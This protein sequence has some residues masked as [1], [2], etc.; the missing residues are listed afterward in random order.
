MVKRARDLGGARLGMLAVRDPEGRL[1]VRALEGAATGRRRLGEPLRSPRW[2]VLM[3]ERVPLVTTPIS[4]PSA[5]TS[6]A[7]SRTGMRSELTRPT[8]LREAPSA[9]WRSMTAAPG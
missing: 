8:R 2:P 5:L 1:V 4:W 7:P 9:N 6:L 3:R